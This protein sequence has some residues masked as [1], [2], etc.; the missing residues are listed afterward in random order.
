MKSN[1]LLLPVLVGFS[2]AVSMWG[3]DRGSPSSSGADAAAQPAEKAIPAPPPGPPP[4]PTFSEVKARLSKTTFGEGWR[5]SDEVTQTAGDDGIPG[6]ASG[7]VNYWL[8]SRALFLQDITGKAVEPSKRSF[9]ATAMAKI[10]EINEASKRADV[11]SS[12]YYDPRDNLTGAM[13]LIVDSILP[14]KEGAEDLSVPELGYETAVA[15]Q[16]ALKTVR[17]VLTEFLRESEITP[18]TTFVEGHL[19]SRTSHI[20]DFEEWTMTVEDY[21]GKGTVVALK[22][23]ESEPEGS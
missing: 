12:I 17:N 20:R 9:E 16:I 13:F 23:H 18:A 10:A 1:V 22:R 3:C 5:C 4:P 15:K 6:D 8:C 14:A 21:R 7:A 2:L 11:T 19:P